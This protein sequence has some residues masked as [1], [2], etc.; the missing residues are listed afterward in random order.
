MQFDSGIIRHLYIIMTLI[1][2]PGVAWYMRLII[3]GVALFC[4]TLFGTCVCDNALV[5]TTITN[6]MVCM[7]LLLFKPSHFTSMSCSHCF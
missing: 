1:S 3:V 6:L 5:K 4:L 7:S 2:F